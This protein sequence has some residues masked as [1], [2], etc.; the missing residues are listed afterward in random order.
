MISSTNFLCFR[1][2]WYNMHIDWRDCMSLTIVI[3]SLIGF[4]LS[5][6]AMMLLMP[7]LIAFLHRVKF[8]Q[9]ER[10]EGLESHKAKN[11]TP[12]MGGVAF[13]ALPVILYGL[14]RLFGLLPQDWNALLVLLAFVGYGLIGFID[15]YIIVVKK[16]NEGL[17]PKQKFLLQSVLAVI[18][19][20]LYMQH[21]T[22]TLYIPVV[23]VQIP[24]GILYFFFIFIMFTAETNAV[25][26][27]DGLD[28]LCAGQMMIA[29]VPYLIFAGM[30]GKGNVFFLIFTLLG[31]LYGYLQFN[32]HPAQVFM[33]DTGSLAL[34]GFLAATAMVLKQELLLLIIGA[35]FVAEV[36]SV[37][38]QVS[39]YKRTKKR[40]FRMAPLHHHFEKGGWSE[41][42]VVQRFWLAGCICS[43]IGLLLGVI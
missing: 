36:L 42:K 2:L 5:I 35:V 9:T 33:G 4:V 14:F 21:G 43:F 10:E 40:I 13:I 37:V 25:N 34:G 16:D 3:Y 15:D 20:I 38:I 41:T 26:F 27:T 30:Q 22:L 19:F 18:F 24:L 11:G 17:K 39:Y 29:L 23:H 1:G 31:A 8:G 6:V 28:G 12:T 32:K 7:R